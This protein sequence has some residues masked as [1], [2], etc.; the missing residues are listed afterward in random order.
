[1]RMDYLPTLFL[2][3]WIIA[4]NIG[5]LSLQA[6]GQVKLYEP[7]ATDEWYQFRGPTGL[8]HAAAYEAPLHWGPEQN[9]EWKTPIPGNGWSSPVLVD[10]KIYLTTAVRDAGNTTLHALCLNAVNGTI[11]WNKEIFQPTSEETRQM[12]SKNSLA[13]PTPIVFDGKL[14][15]HFGHMGTAALNLNG[16]IVWKQEDIDYPPVHGNGGSPALVHDLLVFSCDGGSDP[17]VA[18]LNRHTGK[19]EWKT[20]RRTHAQKTFSFSTPL[21]IDVNGQTQIILP[22]SGLV[23]S[24]RPKDGKE[25]WRVEYGEGYSVVPRPVF[26]H[27]LLYVS[28]S[29][30]SPQAYA[31]NPLGAKGNATDDH[32]VWSQR[33]SAPKTPSM[34][35]VGNQFYMVSDGGVATCL[36]AKTGTVH[37]SERLDGNFSASP[38]AVEDRIY[39]LNE[40]GTTFVIQA[41]TDYN[42]LAENKIGQRTLASPAA[43]DGRFYIRSD[44]HL[45]CFR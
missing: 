3:K 20:A 28:S 43:V 44:S 26:A 18:A 42:L 27:G 36:D 8:G 45:W 16:D 12:H 13:S 17:F 10:G 41:G 6:Y 15:V 1:M 40:T 37:W 2:L 19:I 23:G 7:K 34:I 31:I 24:Y 25:L 38:I 32:I 35:V 11:L 5:I 14:Y 9:V 30:D 21:V 33:R 22:G 39:F 29:F 4:F